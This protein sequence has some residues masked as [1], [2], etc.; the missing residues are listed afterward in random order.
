M[1]TLLPL[2]LAFG[3]LTQSA[4]GQGAQADQIKRRARATA[5]QN[6]ARQGVAPPPKTTPQP[7]SPTPA[8]RPAAPT[9]PVV[10]PA[11]P[12]AVVPTLSTTQAVAKLE[13]D[14]A[15]FQ[16]AAP[17]TQ[18]HRQQLLRDIAQSARGQK[19]F[20][21]TATGFVDALGAALAGRQLDAEHRNRFAQKLEAVLNC[22][23]LPAAQ[24]DGLIA[25]AQAALESGGV[26]R[27]KAAEVARQLRL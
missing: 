20:L 25:D 5:E 8:Q 9:A 4:L 12:T 19:P 18:E 1:K 21:T 2:L 11:K 6:N 24:L 10:A 23:S 16:S 13:A 15:A 17:A 3:W 7:A 27:E 22:G 26:P 14:L